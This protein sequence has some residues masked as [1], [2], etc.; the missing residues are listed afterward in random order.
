M[1]IDFSTVWLTTLVL[2][3]VFVSLIAFS[4]IWTKVWAWIDDRS[5]RFKD[6]IFFNEHLFK[7]HQKNLKEHYCRS[8]SQNEKLAEL[9]GEKRFRI[10]EHRHLSEEQFN[11]VKEEYPELI[12]T[13]YVPRLHILL[14]IFSPIVLWTLMN[15]WFIIVPFA[16]IGAG[17]Y[18]ARSYRRLQ[19]RLE[20]LNKNKPDSK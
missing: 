15:F 10:A 2:C 16:M 20:L 14:A 17:L 11:K 3:G 8:S 18:G 7:L 6:T 4:L 12:D 19:K 1:D 5:M 13:L 9:L